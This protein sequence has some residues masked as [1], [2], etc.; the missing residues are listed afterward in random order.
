MCSVYEMSQD[1]VEVVGSICELAYKLDELI[2]QVGKKELRTEE[3]QDK[4]SDIGYEFLCIDKASTCSPELFE[5]VLKD[6]ERAVYNGSIWAVDFY[7]YHDRV[8]DFY[9]EYRGYI[10]AVLGWCEDSDY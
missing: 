6:L 4:L 10:T 2:E 8:D 7:I 3:I 5:D 9:F 1:E